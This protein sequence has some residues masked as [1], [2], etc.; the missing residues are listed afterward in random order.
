MT[1][2]LENTEKNKE[3]VTA[4][5]PRNDDCCIF[6]WLFY[7]LDFMELRYEVWYDF[8]LFLIYYFDVS[9]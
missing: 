9:S 5:P 6:F 3:K 4:L 2:Y 8:Y 1:E 7:N